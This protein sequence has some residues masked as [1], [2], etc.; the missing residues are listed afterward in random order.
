MV[1]TDASPVSWSP[2]RVR[3]RWTAAMVVGEVMGLGGAGLLAL[4]ATALV[5]DAPPTPVVVLMFVAMLAAGAVEGA[6]VGGV[7]SLVLVRVLPRVPRRPWVI[8]TAV[9]ALL[10]WLIGAGVVMSL[11]ENQAFEDSLPLFM[12]LGPVLGGLLGGC[13]WVVLRRH[14][15]GA[16]W[17]VLANAAG[18][19]LGLLVGFG[20]PMSISEDTPIALA[21]ALALLTG[22]GTGLAP[23]L[24]TAEALVRLLRRGR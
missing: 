20:V 19:G 15:P 21:A 24:V 18:W 14:V 12:A 4:G 1:R 23:G 6:V 17:W 5:G 10:A 11:P 8:A 3:L 16:A 2:G 22:A 7:Q 13:Q 9:G